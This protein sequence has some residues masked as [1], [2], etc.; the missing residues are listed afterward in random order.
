[1]AL[2]K[3]KLTSEDVAV[4]CP[5]CHERVPGGVRQCTM[6]GRSVADVATEAARERAGDAQKR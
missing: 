6:C 3:R 2:F 1:M 5:H 4:R